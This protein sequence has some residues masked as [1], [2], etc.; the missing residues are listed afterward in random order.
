MLFRSYEYYRTASMATALYERVLSSLSLSEE[1]FGEEGREKYEHLRWYAFMCAEGY[2]YADTVDF[3]GKL[4]SAMTA[5]AESDADRAD[6]TK[7]PEERKKLQNGMR[8]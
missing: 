6:K 2:R 4:H 8:S 7:E 1:D 3:V 5:Y